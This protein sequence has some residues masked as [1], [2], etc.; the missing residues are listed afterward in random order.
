MREDN[1]HKV[2]SS[3]FPFDECNLFAAGLAVLS[4]GT[5]KIELRNDH[6]H[7]VAQL[8]DIYLEGERLDREL[9]VLRC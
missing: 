1:P 5:A 4:A 3:K 7:L 6:G 8:G 2:A 9:T